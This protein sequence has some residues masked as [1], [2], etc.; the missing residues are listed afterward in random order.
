MACSAGRRVPGYLLEDLAR[1]SSPL[2][3]TETGSLAAQTDGIFRRFPSW[4][5]EEKFI[6][7]RQMS[8]GPVNRLGPPGT[9]KWLQSAIH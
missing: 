3:Q 4:R 8:S 2:S 7:A 1:G 5:L 6:P 9:A